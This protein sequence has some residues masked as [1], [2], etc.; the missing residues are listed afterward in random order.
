MKLNSALIT[1][2]L[3][4]L[5]SICI[6]D[7]SQAFCKADCETAK[8]H[9]NKD[10]VLGHYDLPILQSYELA[11]SVLDSSD[12]EALTQNDKKTE[13]AKDTHRL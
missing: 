2:I 11:Q 7:S 1:T 3:I 10:F 6:S 9:P 12:I 8:A 5:F 4:F 13:V